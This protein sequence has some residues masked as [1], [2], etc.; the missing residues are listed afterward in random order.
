MQREIRDRGAEKWWAKKWKTWG[1]MALFF[2]PPFFCLYKCT[3]DISV[4]VKMQFNERASGRSERRGR[5]GFRMPERWASSSRRVMLYSV[6][7]PTAT[8]VRAIV[9][10][11]VS[12]TVRPDGHYF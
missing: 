12:G 3:S 6:K 5:I 2:C 1:L 10:A 4:D 8:L 9:L 7:A 11:F